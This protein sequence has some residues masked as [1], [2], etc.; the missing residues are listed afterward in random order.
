MSAQPFSVYLTTKISTCYKRLPP[1]EALNNIISKVLGMDLQCKLLI[2]A[3][4]A[5]TAKQI[6]IK[7]T[8]EIT[9]VYL[10]IEMHFSRKCTFKDF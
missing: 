3:N 7:D 1:K 2:N 6:M 10:S 8:N 5:H 9:P 4:P